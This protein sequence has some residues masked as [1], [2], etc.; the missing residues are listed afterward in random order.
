MLMPTEILNLLLDMLNHIYL[1]KKPPV[2]WLVS[3]LAP[4]LNFGDANNYKAIA[5]V[6]V[7][8]K[9][10]NRITTDSN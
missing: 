9:L 3:I 8:A 5:L 7:S 6:S 10:H 1:S 2:E 4:V